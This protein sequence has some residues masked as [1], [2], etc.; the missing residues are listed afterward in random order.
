V[1]ILRSSTLRYDFGD[2][3]PTVSGPSKLTAI[4]DFDGPAAD[5]VCIVEFDEASRT[6][7]HVHDQGQ[8]L[9]ILDGEGEIQVEGQAPVPI[10]A[11]DVVI[12]EPG[13]KHWHG[14]TSGM[15]LRHAAISRGPVTWLGEV[16][17][18][19]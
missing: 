11:G 6:H 1:N 8:I 17:S 2:Q 10:T 12:A 16:V 9:V 13:E 7:W 5:N 18:E 4:W 15:R 14:A 3:R 19:S